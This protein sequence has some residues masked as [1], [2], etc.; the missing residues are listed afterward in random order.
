[1]G[2][3]IAISVLSIIILIFLFSAEYSA[4]LP[5]FIYSL[6][7]AGIYVMYLYLD[8]VDYNSNIEKIGGVSYNMPLA[9]YL[10]NNS[11]EYIKKA[12]I[13]WRKNGIEN[14]EFY[15]CDGND[16]FSIGSCGKTILSSV[17]AILHKNNILNIEDT[18]DK[19]F[20]DT[21]NGEYVNI[22]SIMI[23]DIAAHNGGIKDVVYKTVLYDSLTEGLPADPVK[24]RLEF[25]SRLLQYL[26]GE[27]HEN[28]KPDRKKYEYSNNGYCILASIIET[29][30]GKDYRS[31]IEEYICEQVGIKLIYGYADDV[32]GQTVLG[33]GRTI[34]VRAES[35]DW[36][37]TPFTEPSGDMF[38]SLNDL[39][40][41]AKSH[42]P[43]DNI[44]DDVLYSR[45]N[46]KKAL[47]WS[48]NNDYIFH[49][50]GAFGFT[51]LIKIDRM[52]G[53]CLVAFWD[54]LWQ[55]D[56]GMNRYFSDRI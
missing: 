52:S 15:G 36:L 30:T 27:K 13:I 7:L 25:S 49:S 10:K 47:G 35:S 32:S 53:D 41:F 56:F 46:D 17:I 50:G 34:P 31:V 20:S 5:I 48:I 12:G 26:F 14:S 45:I 51:S 24:C 9:E 43:N 11:G 3:L 28:R 37:V 33:W 55:D 4:V 54:L 44:Y 19:Y 16:L 21:I 23:K 8:S 39:F 2:L 6:I 40:K 29:A 38:M 1:M 42:S 22:S 18:I